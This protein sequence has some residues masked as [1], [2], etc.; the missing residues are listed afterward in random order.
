MGE[1]MLPFKVVTSLV[2]SSDNDNATMPLRHEFDE[3]DLDVR[4]ES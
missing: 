4:I 1:K 2:F 3:D